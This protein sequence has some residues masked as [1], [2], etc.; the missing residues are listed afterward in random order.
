LILLVALSLIDDYDS[1]PALELLEKNEDELFR[2]FRDIW[3]QQSAH[4][5]GHSLDLFIAEA[6][7][8]ADYSTE[9]HTISLFRL[10]LEFATNGE[11]QDVYQHELNPH[12]SANYNANI[13]GS[14][15]FIN[16]P[17][18]F[19]SFDSQKMFDALSKS[20]VF[21]GQT[22]REQDII[23]LRTRMIDWLPIGFPDGY[24]V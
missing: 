19:G 15:V 22:I 20:S 16:G 5:P 21:L 7:R 14:L 9:F 18:H 17:K 6:K 4:I 23:E 1:S 3:T 12:Y 11:K 13:I 10:L 2:G 8:T 24:L